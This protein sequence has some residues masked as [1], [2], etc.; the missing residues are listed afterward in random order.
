MLGVAI[1][2][3]AELEIAYKAAL[4]I[5]ESRSSKD[6]VVALPKNG[7]GEPSPAPEVTVSREDVKAIAAKIIANGRR[8]DLAKLLKSFGAANVGVLDADKLAEFSVQ[9]EELV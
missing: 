7:P 4:E 9:A 5:L 1:Q 8:N 2:T 6:N 3:K